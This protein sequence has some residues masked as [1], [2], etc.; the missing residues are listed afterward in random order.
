MKIDFSDFYGAMPGLAVLVIAESIEMIWEHRFNKDKN[1]MFNSITIG[2]VAI[3]IATFCKGFIFLF[4]SWLY[5]FRILTISSTAWWAWIICFFADDISYYGFHR[6][7]HQVRFLWASHA[8]HHSPQIFTLSSA[9]RMP[10]TSIVTGNFL[11][12]SWMPLIGL[13]PV[14]V[15]TI[16]SINAVYQFWLHTEKIKKL[17]AW[18]EAVFNTP[19]H[20]RVH[21]GSDADYL[22]KNHGGT[23][24]IWDRMFGTYLNETHKPVYGLTKNVGSSNPFVIAFHEWNNIV[25]DLRKAKT[26]GDRMNFIFNSPGWTNDRTNKATCTLI[27]DAAEKMTAESINAI[28]L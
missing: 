3:A 21:H 10:W 18:F 1:E 17:P 14:M 23:L 8:V 25:K 27:A 24:I 15:I 20:H 12:W 7:S 22:D 6:C 9:L 4:F 28:I 26:T 2:I 5:Q 13:S 16:K 19:S 11:F